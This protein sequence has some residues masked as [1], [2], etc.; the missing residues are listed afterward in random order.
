MKKGMSICAVCLYLAAVGL[1]IYSMFS[2]STALFMSFGAV[3]L[4]LGAGMTIYA[5]KKK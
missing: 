4:C 3:A 1:F 5:A 2:D